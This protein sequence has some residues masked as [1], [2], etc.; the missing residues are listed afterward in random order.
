MF[1]AQIVAQLLDINS[2]ELLTIVVALKLWGSQLSGRRL[3]VRCDNEVAVT[4]LNSGRCKHPF[5]NACLREICFMSATHEFELRAVHLPGVKNHEADLLS[6][7]ARDSIP[8]ERFLQR[9][10][11]DALIDVPVPPEYFELN[12]AC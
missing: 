8:K 7:W 12:D 11:R 1:P 5:L 9:A 3:T 6:R 10:A 2:L 4:V